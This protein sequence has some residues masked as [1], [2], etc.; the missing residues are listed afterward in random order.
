MNLTILL[1]QDIIFSSV[2][3][4]PKNFSALK[5]FGYSLDPKYIKTPAQR[6]PVKAV[7][8]DPGITSG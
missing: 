2:E 4:I 5:F 3:V 8:S 1:L 6:L 7:G